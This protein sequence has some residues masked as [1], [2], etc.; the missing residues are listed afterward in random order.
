MKFIFI[1]EE[2]PFYVYLFFE[3]FFKKYT[4]ESAD[5]KGIVILEPF[6]KKSTLALAKKMFGFYGLF[7]FIRMGML[8]VFKKLKGVS[9][10]NLTKNYNVPVFEVENVNDKTF[11]DKLNALEVDLVISVAAP[12]KFKAEL[13]SIPG[14]GCIN[15]HSGKLPKYRGMLPSFWTLLNEKKSGA[16]TIHKMNANLDDGEII[17]QQDV[18]IVP[19]ET[20][21]SYIKKTKKLGAEMMLRAIKSFRDDKVE[22]KPNNK[23]ES[24]YNSF[25]TRD[26]VKRF[27]RQGLKFF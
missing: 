24:T 16:V 9:I 7:N 1:T 26:D 20:L 22:L 12:Q 23:N 13:L 10:R 14:K 2:D 3:T 19:N 6:D 21:D 5:L 15:I 18:E 8:Y 11:L 4:T 17:L 25:P 27:R